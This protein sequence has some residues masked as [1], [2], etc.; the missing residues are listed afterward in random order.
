M[1]Y[2]F[3][4]E[5]CDVQEACSHHCSSSLG[6]LPG[7]CWR[8]VDCFRGCCSE[9]SKRLNSPENAAKPKGLSQRSVLIKTMDFCGD[10][11]CTGLETPATCPVD[12]CFK[13]NSTCTVAPGHCVPVCCQ[14]DS[15]CNS[16]NSSTTATATSDEGRRSRI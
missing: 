9:A 5:G 13:V 12:C 11:E 7:L 15:C 2:F 10:G 16:W 3:N 8:W 6:D 14:F 4:C 1:K